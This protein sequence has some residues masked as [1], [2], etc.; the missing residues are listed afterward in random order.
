MIVS[1]SMRSSLA[2]A[3]ET[4]EARGARAL[5]SW[6]GTTLTGKGQSDC[7]IFFLNQQKRHGWNLVGLFGELMELETPPWEMTPKKVNDIMLWSRF[8]TF[9]ASFEAEMTPSNMCNRVKQ[10]YRA[11]QE[12]PQS[13]TIRITSFSRFVSSVDISGCVKPGTL[14]GWTGPSGLF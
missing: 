13:C 4:N 11:I 14:L 2:A 9:H 10:F 3:M 1:A 8:D 6:A 5:A 12:G 7:G